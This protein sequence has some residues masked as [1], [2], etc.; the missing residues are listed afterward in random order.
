MKVIIAGSRHF[1]TQKVGLEGACEM[2]SDALGPITEVV[3]GCAPGIDTLGREWALAR[4]IPVKEFPADWGTHGRAAGPVRN[5]QMAEYA[6]A[7]ILIWDG[8]SRGSASMKREAERAGI[9]LLEINT[10]P[11]AARPSSSKDGQR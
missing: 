4:N 6:D 8:G 11:D 1:E 10:N 9:A 5:R 2:F 3:C 7:L